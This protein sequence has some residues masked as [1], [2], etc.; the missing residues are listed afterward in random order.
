MPGEAKSNQ[1][2]AITGIITA[3]NAQP[4]KVW[5]EAYGK[6][7]SGDIVLRYVQDSATIHSN[8]AVNGQ[9]LPNTLL[10]TGTNLGFDALNG[11][12]PGCNEFAGYV[13]FRFKVGQP[14][15]EVAKTVS[16]FGANNFVESVT[17]KPGDQ[18]EYKIAYKNTGSTRQDNVVIKDQLPAGVEYVA[19]SAKLAN[20][21][22]NG[23]QSVSDNIVTNTGINI[24]SYAENG[25]NAFVKFTAKVTDNSKLAACGKN[26]LTNKA[27]AQTTNG[28]KSDTADV[29]V[30]KTCAPG[31]TTPTPVVPQELPKTGAGETILSLIGLG[32]IVAAISYYVTSRRSLTN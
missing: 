22:S 32:A 23:Y 27:I 6:S 24:G 21:E 28:S 20:S 1:N 3:D 8:G 29:V 15:F 2:V 26:T 10:T 25:G 9:K 31:T 11:N 17:A 30:M 16:T 7:T 19:G 12:L 14:N 18:V 13:T 5:D 4:L